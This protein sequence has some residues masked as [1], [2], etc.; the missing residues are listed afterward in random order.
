LGS[1]R[2]SCFWCVLVR[3]ISL[4]RVTRFS[5]RS[6]QG[7]R[8]MGSGGRDVSLCFT[9]LRAFAL[10]FGTLSE[11]AS[12]IVPTGT[13]RFAL[14]GEFVVSVRP[15]CSSGREGGAGLPAEA[16][17]GPVALHAIRATATRARHASRLGDFHA[18]SAQG[19]PLATAHEQRMG[20]LVERGAG[21]LIPAAADGTVTETGARS[22]DS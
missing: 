11:I 6:A 22:E 10:R 21:E 19:R 5:S 15:P 16:E 12:P 20:R 3:I 14:L 9:T 17:L 4:P 18:P 8:M 7:R 2:S 1:E 13:I